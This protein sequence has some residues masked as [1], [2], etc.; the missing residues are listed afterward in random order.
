LATA[1]RDGV[2]NLYLVAVVVDNQMADVD[3]AIGADVRVA[4]ILVLGGWVR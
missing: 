1:A 2:D 4:L 3:D